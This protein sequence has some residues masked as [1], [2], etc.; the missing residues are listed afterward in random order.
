MYLIEEYCEEGDLAYHM[1][2]RCKYKKKHYTEETVVKWVSQML[3]A[4]EYL[5]ERNILHKDL[6]PTNIFLTAQGNIKLGSLK[7]N[8]VIVLVVRPNKRIKA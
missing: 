8:K 2:R 3:M 6:R 1:H 4:L 5:H 7:L